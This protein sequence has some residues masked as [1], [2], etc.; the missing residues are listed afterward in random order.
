MNYLPE[1]FTGETIPN[2][3]PDK[4]CFGVFAKEDGSLMDLSDEQVMHLHILLVSMNVK[5]YMK[6]KFEGYKNEDGTVHLDNAWR[7]E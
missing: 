7:E 2:L 6:V 5:P 1:K 4:I 3:I